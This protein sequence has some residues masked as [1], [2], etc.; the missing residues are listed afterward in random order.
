MY[1]YTYINF[2]TT[3]CRKLRTRII[4]AYFFVVHLGNFFISQSLT[5]IYIGGN[6]A[7][8]QEIRYN[9]SL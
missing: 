8:I 9:S 5:I 3:R 7:L 1:I 4:S 2:R 6:G